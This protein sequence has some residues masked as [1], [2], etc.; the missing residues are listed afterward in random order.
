MIFNII[1]VDKIRLGFA[2][3][4][5]YIRRFPALLEKYDFQFAIYECEFLFV[6][7]CKSAYF[8]I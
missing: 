4:W 7:L 8:T 3:I 1:L 6:G 2:E 5:D